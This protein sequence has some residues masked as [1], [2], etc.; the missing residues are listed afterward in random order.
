MS[1][2]FLKPNLDDDIFKEDK[3]DVDAQKNTTFV[4]NPV[5]SWSLNAQ[6]SRLPIAKNR[7]DILYL[8]ENHQVLVIVGDTGC[9]KSTQVPQFLAEAGWTD[10]ETMVPIIY[11]FDGRFPSRHKQSFFI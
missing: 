1:R 6:K 7:D 5:P 11:F 8:L 4:Y 3:I 9:G 2:G 10:S